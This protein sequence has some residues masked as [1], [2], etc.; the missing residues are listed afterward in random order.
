MNIYLLMKCN[1]C[2][3]CKQG[4]GVSAFSSSFQYSVKLEKGDYTIRLQVRHERKDLL[5]RLKDVPMLVSHKLPSN[6][7]LDVYR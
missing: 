3:P 5:E 7:S 4:P 2:L 6:I 1:L